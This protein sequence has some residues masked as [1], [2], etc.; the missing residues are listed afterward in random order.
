MAAPAP[1][2]P[3]EPAASA[4]AEEEPVRSS[5]PAQ[6]ERAAPA[7]A[8][9]E[10]PAADSASEEQATS[11]S[12]PRAL[13]GRPVAGDELTTQLSEQSSTL[14]RHEKRLATLERRET[15]TTVG[16]RPSPA[17]VAGIVAFLAAEALVAAVVLALDSDLKTWAAAAIVG[18]GL[19]VIAVL[20]A[21]MAKRNVD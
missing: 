5:A 4:P 3:D 9:H 12:L 15:E 14:A 20:V 8:E 19:M 17:F 18:V 11:G 2:V 13:T 16:I 21:L 10:E 1:P 7:P 6:E